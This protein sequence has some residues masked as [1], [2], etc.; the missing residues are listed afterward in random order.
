MREMDEHTLIV[1]RGWW[2]MDV[3]Y[4]LTGQ[5]YSPNSVQPGSLSLDALDQECFPFSAVDDG[6]VE[7]DEVFTISLR[8]TD[9]IPS[10][11]G[12]IDVENDLVTVTI[13]APT[14]TPTPGVDVEGD[15]LIK[16]QE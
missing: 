8:S 3:H 5:D 9:S 13:V 14:P 1:T 11:T 7:A 6:V 16:F 12:A 2:T 15:A 4:V 10:G